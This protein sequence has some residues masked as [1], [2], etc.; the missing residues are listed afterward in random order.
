MTKDKIKPFLPYIGLPVVLLALAILQVNRIVLV[1][2]LLN[3]LL[4]GFGYVA[5]V[6]DIKTKTIP[7]MLVLAMLAGWV[8]VIVPHLFINTDS[9]INLLW[10]SLLGFAV[11][12]AMFLI[13]YII[14]RKGL[15]GGDVKFMAV[16]GLYL[17]LSG[18]LPATLYGTILAAL[19]GLILIILKKIGRKDSIPLVPFLYIG[20]LITL[21]LM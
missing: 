3:L 10:D 17:G 14:S 18:V 9:T 6:I 8:L 12:A 15:G 21:F 19:A 11:C 16:A 2:L 20:I 7:N 4:A 5:S 1:V 13:I